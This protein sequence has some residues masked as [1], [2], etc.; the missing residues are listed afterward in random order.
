MKPIGGT[1]ALLVLAVTVPSCVGYDIWNR[2]VVKTEKL[3]EAQAVLACNPEYAKV[4][5]LKLPDYWDVETKVLVVEDGNGSLFCMATSAG[6]DKVFGTEDD[7]VFKSQ[8]INKSRIAGAWMKKKGAEAV[9]GI[10]F[11]DRREETN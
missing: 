5:Q 10:I 3:I 11:G 2:H 8:N 7:L 9:K 6:R 1:T 4:A